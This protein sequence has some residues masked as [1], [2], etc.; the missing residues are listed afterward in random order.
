MPDD[1]FH[2]ARSEHHA[3]I[4]RLKWWLRLMPRRAVLHR[5]PFIG[6]FAHL[7]RDRFHLWSFRKAH[8]RPAYYLGSILSFLPVMGIQLPLALVLSLLFR[9]NFMILGGLQFITNPLTAAPIYYGTYQ[10]GK[11]TIALASPPGPPALE[12]EPKL[13]EKEAFAS[14]LADEVLEPADAPK[15]GWK[16]RVRASVDALVVGG[17]IVGLFVGGVFDA[18][19]TA[20]RW[21]TS[22][23]IARVSPRSPPSSPARR[24]AKSPPAPHG[25][26]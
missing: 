21:R 1:A 9:T 12:S 5:Y 20:V 14:A 16:S 13:R 23:R 22:R 6:R 26:P 11:A 25:P 4:R 17:A 2:H 10:L 15:P 8:V 18:A 19:D 24:E 3:R 7:L